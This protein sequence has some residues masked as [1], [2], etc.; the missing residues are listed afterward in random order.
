MPYATTLLAL[1]TYL[2]D[3][4]IQS[5][6]RYL[7]M[8]PELLNEAGH[9]FE[10]YTQGGIRHTHHNSDDS[11]LAWKCF[12]YEHHIAGRKRLCTVLT[13]N[14]NASQAARFPQPAL[15]ASLIN[16]SARARSSGPINRPRAPPKSS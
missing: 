13:N 1:S 11:P 3:V 16:S 9:R 7:T 14:P 12:K 8:T 15:Q 10:Q 4:D 2:G 5:T 6:Q